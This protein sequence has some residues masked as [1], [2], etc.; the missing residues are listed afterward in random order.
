MSKETAEGITVFT[1]FILSLIAGAIL[2]LTKK[3]KVCIEYKE[4]PI[5]KTECRQILWQFE[6][7]HKQETKRSCVKYE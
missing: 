3:E 5:I 7:T 2:G 4:E 1:F 6:C